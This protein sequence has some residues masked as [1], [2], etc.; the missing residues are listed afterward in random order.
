MA[1][2]IASR[3]YS[4]HVSTVSQAIK[5][6]GKL[7]PWKG[8]LDCPK[9]DGYDYLGWEFKVEQYFEVVNMVEEDKVQTVLIHLKGKALQWH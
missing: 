6:L 5:E 9:F 3:E 1:A 4:V 8:K 2:G 7:N